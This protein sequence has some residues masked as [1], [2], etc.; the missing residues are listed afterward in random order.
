MIRQARLLCHRYAMLTASPADHLQDPKITDPIT[1]DGAGQRGDGQI[2]ELLTALIR[3]HTELDG[4]TD[5]LSKD[6][7]QGRWKNWRIGCRRKLWQSIQLQGTLESSS[8]NT[9]TAF[10]RFTFN[11]LK[12]LATLIACM[13]SNPKTIHRKDLIQSPNSFVHLSTQ[14]SSS[15]EHPTDPPADPV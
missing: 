13:D 4:E 8:V 12:A 14:S 15:K 11:V 1:L 6:L 2:E 9:D 5:C 3:R 7:S 10:L